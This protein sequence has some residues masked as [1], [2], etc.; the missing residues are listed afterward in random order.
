MKNQDKKE[1]KSIS[2]GFFHVWFFWLGIFGANP[3]N[4]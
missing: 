2:G 1:E 4:S 3:E